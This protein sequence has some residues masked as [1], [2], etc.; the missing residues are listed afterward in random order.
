MKNIKEDERQ[1]AAVEIHA[2]L[3]GEKQMKKLE[4][5]TDGGRKERQ[6]G[7]R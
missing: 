1:K 2:G 5:K 7:Q 6:R 3:L 4:K